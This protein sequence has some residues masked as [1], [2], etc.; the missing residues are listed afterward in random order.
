MQ[1]AEFVLN[2]VLE[3]AIQPLAR[4]AVRLHVT[5]TATA[6]AYSGCIGTFYFADL[7][8]LN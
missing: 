5:A 3:V 4:S 6:A 7:I 2:T 1:T 8:S